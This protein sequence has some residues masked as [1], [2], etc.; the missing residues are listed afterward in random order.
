MSEDK[1][2]YEF[3]YDTIIC[4]TE[5]IT[6]DYLVEQFKNMILSDIFPS[7]YVFPN[8]NTLC[9]QIGVGRSTL[10]EAFKVLSAYGLITRTKHGTFINDSKDFNS[11]FV[12][13]Y[14]FQE[15]DPVELMEFRK[16]F[17]SETSY[18]A[19][20]KATTDDIMELK[21]LLIKMENC[22][23]NISA[24]S[25]HDVAFHYR[26]AYCTQNK[27]LISIMKLI[28]DTYYKGVRKQF[29]ELEYIG[30]NTTYD[31]T[32]YYH[33]KIFDAILLKNSEAASN[34]MREHLDTV[35]QELIKLNKN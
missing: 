22:K 34:T 10:R 27:L 20:Q 29:E 7:G 8:E 3:P 32:L 28:S 12:I 11:S 26:I 17:E 9:E 33:T 35:L 13:N 14:N 30:D 19:A 31:I 16:I 18:L 4:G 2:L 5:K 24:L 23:N 6:S 15:S 25:F 21:K 1:L